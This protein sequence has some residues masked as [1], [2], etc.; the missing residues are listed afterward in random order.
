MCHLRVYKQMDGLKLEFL[1]A[2]KVLL[3]PKAAAVG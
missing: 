1:R 3:E 2:H